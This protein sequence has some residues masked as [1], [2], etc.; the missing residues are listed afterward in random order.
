MIVSLIAYS[1]SSSYAKSRDSILSGTGPP[2]FFYEFQRVPM[3]SN[4]FWWVPVVSNYFQLVPIGPIN[5]NFGTL[6]KILFYIILGTFKYFSVFLNFFWYFQVLFFVRYFQMTRFTLKH[7]RI[8]S[9]TFK[10]FGSILGTFEYFRQIV[11]YHQS[12]GKI[13]WFTI[14]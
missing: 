8:I 7:F 5:S 4:W 3:S 2:I 12:D 9:G 11:F 1:Y 13:V 10:L 6:K 14:K